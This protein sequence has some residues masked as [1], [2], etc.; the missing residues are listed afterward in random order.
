[1]AGHEA[2]INAVFE[3]EAARF[4]TQQG[5]GLVGWLGSDGGRAV[6]AGDRHS[7]N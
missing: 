1:M 5:F 7:P 3:G 2:A 6:A 4:A